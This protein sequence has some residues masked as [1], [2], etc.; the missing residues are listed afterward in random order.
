MAWRSLGELNEEMVKNFKQL[1]IISSAVVESAFLNVPRAA[2]L[3]EYLHDD[4]YGDYPVRGDDHLHMSA[5]HMY[6]TVLEALDLKE[7]MSFLN[8]GSGTGYFSMLA[9]YVIGSQGVNHGVE[10]RANLVEHANECCEEFFMYS[11]K[12]KKKICY[13]QFIH[14]NCFHIDTTVQKYD[15]LYCGAACP[16]ERFDFLLHLVKP[17]GL[18]VVPSGNKLLKLERLDPSGVNENVLSDVCFE[19]LVLPVDN[20]L[21]PKLR[22][23]SLKQKAKQ[24]KIYPAPGLL[25]PKSSARKSLSR[26]RALQD[27]VESLT[28]SG[29][30]PKPFSYVPSF[31]QIS[32]LTRTPESPTLGVPSS[33]PVDQVVTFFDKKPKDSSYSKTNSAGSEHVD[34]LWNDLQYDTTWENAVDFTYSLCSNDRENREK[35]FQLYTKI[36]RK[37]KRK[38]RPVGVNG[39]SENG[40]LSNVK[41]ILQKYED[42]VDEK[43]TKAGAIVT[44]HENKSSKQRL[45]QN[46]SPC[47]SNQS[48]KNDGDISRLFGQLE[49]YGDLLTIAEKAIDL[50]IESQDD[51]NISRTNSDANVKHSMENRWGGETVG[52]NI[53]TS[54]KNSGTSDVLRPRDNCPGD[55]CPGDNCP[56]DN[57]PGD[58]CPGTRGNK[59]EITNNGRK[60]SLQGRAENKPCSVTSRGKQFCPIELDEV[61]TNELQLLPSPNWTCENDTELVQLLV[62]SLGGV[63]SKFSSKCLPKH[64]SVVPSLF[65]PSALARYPKI[66]S[67]PAESLTFRALALLRVVHVIDCVIPLLCSTS[68]NVDLVTRPVTN[69]PY[70]LASF[71]VSSFNSPVS[72][73]EPVIHIHPRSKNEADIYLTNGIRNIQRRKG[74]LKKKLALRE[75]LTGR[76][77]EQQF[78]IKKQMQLFDEQK[79]MIEHAESQAKHMSTGELEQFHL[80]QQRIT[81][82]KLKR[83]DIVDKQTEIAKEDQMNEQE[84]IELR[85]QIKRLD[86]EEERFKQ[87]V[88]NLGRIANKSSQKMDLNE[89]KKPYFPWTLESKREKSNASR[90]LSCLRF[91]LP[92][93]NRRTGILSELLRATEQPLPEQAPVVYV[94]RRACV[95]QRLDNPATS[96]FYQIFESLKAEN[97]SFRWNKRKCEQWWEVKF[98]GEGIIDQGGGFRDSLSEISDELCPQDDDVNKTLPLLIKTVNNRDQVGDHRDCF[99]PNPSCKNMKVFHWLGRLMGAAYRSD[100]T[101]ALYF[102][103]YVWKLLVGEHV[104]WTKDF[105]NVDALAVNM[106]NNFESMKREEFDATYG[107]DLDFT[108]AFSDGTI[109]SVK[110]NGHQ[111]LVDYET[112]L[113]YCQL[114]KKSRMME[115]LDQITSIRDGFLTVIPQSLLELITSHELER[116]VCGFNEISMSLLKESSRQSTCEL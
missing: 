94:D 35:C 52:Q 72:Q 71:T 43:E 98:V 67:C 110:E 62:T 28:Q 97:M 36:K 79:I 6:A 13:P 99:I 22:F 44:K 78:L 25:V 59:A 87:F 105:A 73:D 15:R 47:C 115:F 84:L 20:E 38:S 54:R 109:E 81:E 9:G 31:T 56:G 104:T 19:S 63:S 2:F 17:K 90:I 24:I 26:I 46:D 14:G 23:A 96:V 11:P 3:P 66:A 101:L 116:G 112:R 92:L 30:I 77:K 7:G 75:S 4:A 61:L 39:G 16:R 68:T 34:S 57:C 33:N 5:P 50:K 42:L 49:V 60:P 64:I 108:T 113:E 10:L 40:L 80:V 32:Q 8:I 45:V 89:T 12:L 74:C 91:L 106:I 53:G 103:P 102:P 65:T 85:Q 100:E 1:S 29:R 86:K 21:F 48:A 88:E 51:E 41:T 95:K 58:N 76:F 107:K 55:N 37:P 69:K 70:P 83:N 82:H 18:V 27:V 93:S 114:V 111:L